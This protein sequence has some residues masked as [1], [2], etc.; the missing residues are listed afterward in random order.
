MFPIEDTSSYRSPGAVAASTARPALARRI[1]LQKPD[2]AA[3]IRRIG[4]ETGSYHVQRQSG[5]E[6]PSSW[7]RKTAD[8]VNSKIREITS[9]NRPV[10]LAERIKRPNAY[11]GRWI[12]YFALAEG[13]SVFEVIDRGRMR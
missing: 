11:Q 5:A 1:Q 12:K 6:A 10:R 13:P 4:P 8:W 7:R 9:R 3:T 2:H